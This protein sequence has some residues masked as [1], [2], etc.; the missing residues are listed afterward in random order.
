[1]RPILF[2]IPA[3]PVAGWI[4]LL[5]LL[6]GL[7]TYWAFRE[8]RLEG[9]APE[10]QRRR[11]RG[12]LLFNALF[13]LVA[14]ALLWQFRD[15]VAQPLPVRAYGFFL[16]L[17]FGAGLLYLQRVARGS[18]LPPEGAVDLI[19]GMLLVAVVCARLLYI[20]LQWDSYGGNWRDW[21]RVWEGGLSF[22]GGLAGSIAWVAWYTWRHRLP[23]WWLADLSAPGVALGYAVAR[24][25]CFLNGC[26]YGTPTDLP[27]GVCFADPPLSRHLTP[28]SHPVQLYATLA[29]LA[30]F[31]LLLGFLKRKRYDGQLFGLYLVFYS[32]YRFLA[33]GLRKGVTG[34][35]LGLGLTEAQWASLAIAGVGFALMA[36]LRGR[37]P[38]SPTGAVAPPV[39]APAPAGKEQPRRAAAGATPRAKSRKRR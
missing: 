15:R 23:F 1:M 14:A 25:G 38:A 9:L 29:N 19:L 27:W 22:H 3:V 4:A 17:A 39:A 6:L 26:C 7:S 28:P 12:T 37:A 13:F 2:Q 31:G 34:E 10:E 11:N 24:I 30:I 5:A 21:L 18:A 16:M 35:V 20:V 36:Y 33:E 32:V 8:V